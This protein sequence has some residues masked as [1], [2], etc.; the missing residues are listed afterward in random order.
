MTFEGVTLRRTADGI[1]F[2]IRVATRASRSA[3]VG[4]RDGLLVVHVT[5]PPVDNAANEAVVDVLARALG[6]PRRSVRIVTGLRHR[7]K[8]VEV[9]G[10]TALG[11]LRCS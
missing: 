3:V 4:A 11:S 2:G 5:A 10:L 1:R 6:T 9:S 8:T 7:N